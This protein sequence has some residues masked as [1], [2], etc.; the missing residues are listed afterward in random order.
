[1]N[2]YIGMLFQ[3]RTQTHIYHLQTKS[4][5]KHVALQAYYEGI[6]DLIDGIVEAYQSSYDI[7]TDY[8]MKAS[9]KNLNDDMEIVSYME[10][11]KKYCAIKRKSLPQDDFLKNLYDDVD[12]LISSTLYKV[13]HLS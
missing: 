12:T 3:T 4:Y 1:M 8:T 5:A 7:I 6:V 10:N 11:I 13:K 2:E 9:I